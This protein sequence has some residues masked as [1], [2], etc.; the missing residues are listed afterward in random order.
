MHRKRI[1]LAE[2]CSHPHMIEKLFSEYTDMLTENDP[3]MAEYLSLQHYDA[4][5]A[6]LEAKYGRP[7][8]RLY[9]ALINGEAAGCIGLR[10]LQ[11]GVCEMKRLYV[12]PA[13]RGHGLAKLLTRQVLTDAKE[14]G[15]HTMLLDTL[16]FLQ[17][18]IAL[19]KDLGFCETECYND[20]PVK[21]TIFM[22]KEL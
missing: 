10:Q 3:A 19:Y 16:P 2:G 20:S 17:Q 1:E 5:I 11:D 12:R 9:L 21:T 13:F 18:A 14:I 22:K 7:K 4:E 15:Y 6:D 8:G